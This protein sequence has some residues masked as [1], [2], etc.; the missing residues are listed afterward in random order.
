[1]R[2]IY[3]LLILAALLAAPESWA[4]GGF[5][6]GGSRGSFSSSAGRSFGGGSSKSFSSS[7]SSRSFSSSSR[8]FSSSSASRPSPTIVKN[9]YGGGSG[10]YYHPLTRY[11]GFGMG[12]GYSDGF[13][14]GLILG[15]LLFPTGTT[16]YTSGG[17][18]GNAV[19]LPDGRVADERGYQVGTYVDGKFTPVT[20]GAL[21][22]KPAP[23]VHEDMTPA[24]AIGAGV[25]IAIFV[26]V[27]VMMFL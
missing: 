24:E 18:A 3:T 22:A 17:Y 21:I 16:T 14:E 4:K 2:Y 23:D 15:H 25:L 26:I 12:Y 7:S 27:I 13:V 10:Y 5:S 20:G 6:S 8:S 9:Y 1:M 19:L 11:P